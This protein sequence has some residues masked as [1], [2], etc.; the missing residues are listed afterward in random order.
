MVE[1]ARTLGFTVAFAI[2]LGTMIA[3]GIFSLSG[4]A[5]AAIGSSAV[6]AFVIAALVASIT[7]GAYSEFASIYSESGGGYLFTSRTLEN[8]YVVYAE[9]VMLFLGYSATT[10][11]YLATMGEWVHEFVYP[12]APWIVGTVTAIL[13]AA[14][15]AQGTEESGSFQVLVTGA[16]VAVLLAFIGGAVAYRP[17][18]ESAATF[19]GAFT[20]DLPGIAQIAALA[21][22]TFFGFSAIAASAGE[23]VQPRK[24]VPRAI[25][26]SIVTVT[27]LYALVI[28]AMVNSPVPAEVVAEQGETA[29]GIV[30]E[31]FL[32]PTG[33]ALIVAGAIFSMVSASN[34]SILAA[35]RIGYLMGREGRAVRRFHLIHREW[36]TPIWAI[37]ACMF[38]IVVL[39]VTFVG[40]FPGHGAAPFGINLGLGALTGFANLNLLV[41]LSVVNVALIVSRRRQPDLDRPFRLPLSPVVP[42]V[43]I[44]ANLALIASLPLDGIA[45]G[46]IGILAFLVIYAVWG[47]GVPIEEIMT[48]VTEPSEP[49]EPTATREAVEDEPGGT[50]VLVPVA[51]EE[52]ARDQVALAAALGPLV[53]DGPVSIRVVHITSVPEQTPSDAI[54]TRET[55]ERV[56]QVEAELTDVDA[57]AVLDADV[58]VEGFVS[59][60]VA[61]TILQLA[62]ERTADLIVMGYPEEHR[63]VVDRV[64]H[65]TPCDVVYAYGLDTPVDLSVVNIGAGGGP[66][67][68]ALLPIVDRLGDRGADVHVIRVDPEFGGTPEQVAETLEGLRHADQVQVHNVEERN[69]AKGLVTAARENG[70]VLFIGAS[71]DLLLKQWLF[72]S[73]P[74]R[75]V[76]LAEEAGVPVIIYRGRASVRGTLGDV[77]FLGYRFFRI[78]RRR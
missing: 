10:A 23:I 42:A 69:V 35:S 66:N 71:R 57:D 7:A 78:L 39:I 25:A 32:G 53:G 1:K 21:F 38:T 49:D 46:V 26:A 64:Q 61:F 74:D 75:V 73:T 43:G 55:R 18:A 44:A 20:A 17:P 76:D 24:T 77:A 48:A 63:S 52:D 13:L 51:R 9:G 56:D 60:N 65:R 40:V 45:A 5:V 16:K 59:Q 62:R 50:T 54:D 36:G 11:F 34:A 3:A 47:G 31:A 30:A 70:G 72:G 19:A 29:M 68:L 67:H 33:R 12:V 8:D 22:I 15:N 58:T 27:V 2:G 14:L 41:P 6:I 28:V 37:G 4:T